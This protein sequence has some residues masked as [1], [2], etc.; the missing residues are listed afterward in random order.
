M[1]VQLC[2]MSFRTLKCPV[3]WN[4]DQQKLF[5]DVDLKL[6][7][8]ILYYCHTRTCKIGKDLKQCHDRILSQ[9]FRELMT[10][11]KKQ[12]NALPCLFGVMSVCGSQTLQG[13]SIAY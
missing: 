12:T 5:K 4:N 7:K 8:S 10:R 1:N 11:Q 9:L 6:Q 3:V 13:K 2:R